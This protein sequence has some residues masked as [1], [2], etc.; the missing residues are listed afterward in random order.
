MFFFLGNKDLTKDSYAWKSFTE[1]AQSVRAWKTGIKKNM[2]M[3]MMMIMIDVPR[4]ILYQ[5][6][7]IYLKIHP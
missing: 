6:Y 4:A 3:M 2:M 5:E 1:T 7:W